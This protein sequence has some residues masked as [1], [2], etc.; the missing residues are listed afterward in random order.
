VHALAT[1]AFEE[2]GKAAICVFCMGTSEQ[3]PVNDWFFPAFK[4][5]RAKITIAR[6]VLSM[7]TAYTSTE[8]TPAQPIVQASVLAGADHEMKMRG[9]YVDFQ[10]GDVLQPADVGEHD[11]VGMVANVTICLEILTLLVTDRDV[12]TDAPTG[13]IVK[14]RSSTL[15]CYRIATIGTR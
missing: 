12:A 5:H 13:S 2:V 7:F 9:L 8:D 11:A 6:F 15:D 14:R 10:H 4:D 1:S 3:F